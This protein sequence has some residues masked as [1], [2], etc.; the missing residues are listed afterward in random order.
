MKNA[1]IRKINTLGTV[2]YIISILVIIV[3]IAGIVGTVIAGFAALG[4]SDN[5]LNVNGKVTAEIDV[6]ESNLNPLGRFLVESGHVE[7]V[8]L[9][10]ADI[11]IN[12]F[13]F[14]MHWNVTE[15][16]TGENTKTYMVDGAMDEFNGATVKYAICTGCFF[17]AA[18]LALILVAAFFGKN[19]SRKLSKC[20][21]PFH[22]EVIRAMKYFAYSLIPFGIAS[23]TANGIGIIGVLAVLVVFLFVFTFSY[24]AE[25]QKE[26]D[27]TL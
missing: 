21:S 24:G 5:A 19:L 11:K 14:K 16:K 7:I 6:D 25:L 2:S 12:N 20:E 17:T 27:E 18:V 10:P 23:L 9:E 4:L 26:A 8:N 1:N 15:E 22:E 3:L 13:G